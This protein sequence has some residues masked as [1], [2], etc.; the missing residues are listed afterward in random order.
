MDYSNTRTMK[1][2]KSNEIGKVRFLIGAGMVTGS[3]TLNRKRL[4]ELSQFSPD[5]YGEISVLLYGIYTIMIFIHTRQPWYNHEVKK[6]EKT[7]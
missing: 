1:T 7:P 5:E 4:T 2:K 6:S 3:I